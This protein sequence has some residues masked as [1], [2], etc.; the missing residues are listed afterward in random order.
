MVVQGEIK[1]GGKSEI[2]YPI[3][4]GIHLGQLI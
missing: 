3:V 4:L 2:S 1:A